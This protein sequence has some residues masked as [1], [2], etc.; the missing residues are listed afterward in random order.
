MLF[1][2]NYSH[3]A[4]TL[5]NE[6]RIKIDR[7]KCP[8]WPDM[9][10]EASSYCQ[11]AVHTNLKAGRG[12]LANK[13]WEMISSLLEQTETPFINLHLETRSED[14]PGIPLDTVDPI[15]IEQIAEQTVS[16]L[17]IVIERF[18]SER[19]IAENVPYRGR[20]GKVLRPSS[21]PSVIHQIINETG[22][23]LL[24][25]ISHARISAH[26]LIM[27]EY[28][29]ISELPVNRI[30]ELHFSGVQDQHGRL[31]DHLRALEA[32]WVTLDWVMENIHE[33]RWPKPWLLAF[34]YGG[35]GEKFNNRSDPE[36][37]EEQSNRL[38]EMVQR[39]NLSDL[40]I[41]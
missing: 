31:Q 19:V 17:M 20:S 7:F 6:K 32:D 14:F 26:H 37:I 5:L 13:D 9:I 24:L 15:H 22:C 33:G 38:Y 30:Y 8:D 27:D 28:E 25:D 18:G 3:Q 41:D 34:E 29:Y 1:A 10:A 23:G 39:L 40:G 35:V 36:V 4:A 21:E 12:K 2:L 11:V 16:D